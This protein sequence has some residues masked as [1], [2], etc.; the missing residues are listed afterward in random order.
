M[1]GASEYFYVPD[2]LPV[3]SGFT[4]GL[5]PH[6]AQASAESRAWLTSHNAL[7]SRTLAIFTKANMEQLVARCYPSAPYYE[8]RTVCDFVCLLV[9]IDEMSDEQN[10]ADAHKTGESFLGVLRDPKWDNGT[11]LAAL[12]REFRARL[13]DWVDTDA[14][15]RFVR[16]CENYM[17]GTIREAGLRER[18]EILP[19]AEYQD[20]RRENSAVRPCVALMEYSLGLNLPDAVHDNE[21]F[22]ILYWNVID[23]VCWANDVYS[24]AIEH[25]NGLAGNNVVTVLMHDEGINLQT[26]SNRVGEHYKYLVDTYWTA[27]EALSK[28]TFGDQKLDD[29]VQSYVRE[30]ANWPIGNIVWSFETRRYF[31][32]QKEQVK[33]TRRVNL[34]RA[35]TQSSAV[36][37]RA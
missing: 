21:H 17:N 30:M 2:L 19:T 31:G 22:G 23:M 28:H 20:L 16:H 13:G 10:G 11:P 26:A 12:T 32:D 1:V 29:Q 18:G 6:Y 7:S 36:T 4:L 14:G 27:R 33:A 24:F 34:K 5:N 37:L 9:V 8:F 35:V 25:E 3:S 15:K